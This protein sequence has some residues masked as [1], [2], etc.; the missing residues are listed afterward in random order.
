MS[1]DYFRNTIKSIQINFG[2]G[3]L[4]I[5]NFPKVTGNP[6]I[7]K[8]YMGHDMFQIVENRL[9]QRFPIYKEG[10]S[11]AQATGGTREVVYKMVKGESAFQ[12]VVEKVTDLP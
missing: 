8:G 12:L 1:T 11:N 9:V 4:S 6:K 7:D 5:I 3:G 2:T 10:D